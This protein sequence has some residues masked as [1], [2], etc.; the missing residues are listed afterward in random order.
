MPTSYPL[1][2][3]GFA[4]A[5]LIANEPHVLTEL[6]SATQRIII[7]DFAPFHQDNF[8][9]RH[10][11]SNGVTRDLILDVDYYVC[12]PFIGASRSLGKMVYGGIAINTNLVQGIVSV[13]YQTLGGTW[14]AD[15]T[16]VLERIAERVYNPKT[17][18]WDV[19]TNI[20]QTFPPINHNQ[21]ADS[22]FGMKE[23]IDKLS[24]L[25]AAIAANS[26]SGGGLSV[27]REQLLDELELL[28]T[29]ERIGLS[30]VSNLALASAGEVAAQS[31]VDKYVT[32]KQV[33]DL[34]TLI[35]SSGIKLQDSLNAKTYYL[36]KR[37]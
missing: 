37:I 28:I 10:T 12:L 18:L 24:E 30:L 4:P 35:N 36:M 5:N 19:V 16:Y 3:T 15:P 29:K 13:T 22:F 32:L 20:Q 9:L 6:N 33:L 8:V 25:A 17:T 27:I 2:T 21:E 11:D 1:D 34:V 7:P 14:C 26:A 23:L 31:P